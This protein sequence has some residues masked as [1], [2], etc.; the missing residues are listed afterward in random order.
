[1]SVTGPPTRERAG[2]LPASTTPPCIDRSLRVGLPPAGWSSEPRR[3]ALSDDASPVMVDD[4]AWIKLENAVPDQLGRARVPA[5]AG[6]ARLRAARRAGRGVSALTFPTPAAAA[7][8]RDELRLEARQIG[9]WFKK[10][11]DAIREPFRRDEA[12]TGLRRGG[13]PWDVLPARRETPLRV[14]GSA[15]IRRMI[16][17]GKRRVKGGRAAQR[18]VGFDVLPHAG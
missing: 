2:A 8:R 6:E 14:V 9:R 11:V 15:C 7:T 10:A 18:K 4:A 5:L 3:S 13:P 16:A 17:I 12:R 1:M